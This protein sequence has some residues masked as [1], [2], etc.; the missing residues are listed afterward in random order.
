MVEGIFLFIQVQKNIKKLNERYIKIE[1]VKRDFP[2]EDLEK[3]L[4]LLNDLEKNLG[5]KHYYFHQ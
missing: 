2:I 4:R 1:N 3:K 5:K